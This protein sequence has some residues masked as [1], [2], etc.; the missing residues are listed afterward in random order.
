MLKAIHAQEN[1]E[2]ADTV[3][4]W[5]AILCQGLMDGLL[6]DLLA[7]LRCNAVTS[8]DAFDDGQNR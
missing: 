7:S 3:D 2:A 8:R 4:V 1:R 5:D 6:D